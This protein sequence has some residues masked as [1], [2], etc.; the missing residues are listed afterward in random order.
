MRSFILLLPALLFVC[1]AVAQIPLT[2]AVQI[3]K[4]EDSRTY[5][6]KLEVLMASPNA[7]VRKRV[8][9]AAGRIGDA[10]AVAALSQ[11]VEKDSSDEVRVTAMFALGEIE[12]IEGA[13]AVVS[14]LDDPKA[15]AALRGR[16]IE[17]AG[18][19]AA[20][21]TSHDDAKQL[22]MAIVS[23]LRF[24][25]TKRSAPYEN[26]IRLGATAVLRVRP[27]GADDAIKPFLKYS[28]PAVV[29]DTLN[30]LAR[31]R[32]REVNI[33]ARQLLKTSKD[34]T[35]RAN[36]ARVLGAADARNLIPE[37]LAAA[38]DDSDSRVRVSAIRALSGFR[39][40]ATAERLIEYGEK[41]IA[42]LQNAPKKGAG[43]PIQQNELL[44]IASAIGRMLPNS[45]HAEALGF[46][47]DF[48]VNDALVS[49]EAE[50]A[51]AQIDP[52]GYVLWD[53]AK[54]GGYR[55]WRMASAYAQGMSVVAASRNEKLKPQAGEKLR[56]FVAGMGAG[57][58][59]N[60]QAKFM[61]A[62]PDLMNAMAAFRP[63]NLDDILRGHL[64]NPDVSLRAAAAG[65]LA[66]RPKTEANYEALKAAFIKAR[67]MDKRENDAKLA[68]MDALT[69]L[70][71]KAAVGTLLM[72]LAD[73]DYLIRQKA[74]ALL[75]DKELEKDFP[76]VP[77]MLESSRKE[78][79]DRVLP[80]RPYTGTRLGQVLNFDADYRRA[81]SRKNGSVK[82]V[83]T[84]AKG[85]FTIEFFPEDA[86]LTVDNFVN[87][88]RRGY[89]NGLEVHRVV[90]NFVMQD[91]DPRGDGNGGPGHSIRC[92]INMREYGRGAVGMALSG[93]DTGGSQWFVT[94]SPQPHLDGGYTVFG[95]VSEAEMKVVD[96]IVRG[97]KILTVKIIGK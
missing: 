96:S 79:K 16:A 7:D 83:L 64:E 22:G 10:A 18:K 63:D 46:L 38:T 14:V 23:A 19:V 36:A 4:A 50:I 59:V 56:A 52:E 51:R 81:L 94:H 35:V 80:Y 95:Q 47:A 97:D 77:A 65:L 13:A 78:G 71:K 37:L 5:D 34:P 28:D 20:A 75:A 76:G 39:D 53:V 44:E 2:T 3:A 66:N 30:A 62:M 24:E 21:N 17:A 91:G 70:D 93:K 8:A 15:S 33:E 40:K 12:S 26:V 25:D 32:S 74:F 69:K 49:A 90:P 60:D 43:L 27:A 68:I 73:D 58:K 41:L 72:A 6:A 45:Q 55:D 89:F 88:A 57:V 42:A 67:L 85:S 1:P 86:P 31:L 82:A 61:M 84:T 11:L 29:A 87:L 9:L 48:R 92:E 54:D